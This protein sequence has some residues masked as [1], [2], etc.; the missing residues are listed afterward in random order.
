MRQ[1]YVTFPIRNALRSELSWTHY[2]LL[3]RVTSTQAREFYQQECAQSHW[4]SRQLERQI[5]TLFYERIL[6]SQDK[7]SV[8]AEIEKT[9]P[10][11]E[12][13]KIIKD[14]YV[15]EFLDL[16]ANPH[17]YEKD[18]EQGLIDHLQNFL[19]ELGRGFSFVGRQKRFTFDG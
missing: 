16:P 3:L 18:V 14:P 1:F 19:M 8:A 5:S 11:P 4:S 7:A 6:A 10:K 17:F 2:R 12:Y 15:L 13:E 9:E